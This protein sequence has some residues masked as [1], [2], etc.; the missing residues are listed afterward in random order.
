MQKVIFKDDSLSGN[1]KYIIPNYLPLTSENENDFDFFTFDLGT[2]A[3]ILKFENFLPFGLINQF[4][5]HFGRYED[6]K[7]FWRD[8]LLFTFQKKAKIL[9]HIDF[10]FLEI[11][12]YFGFK[13]V[14]STKDKDLLTKY[15]F[16]VTMCLY[17]DYSILDFEEYILFNNNAK[18][19][20]NF[21]IE[22]DLY[23]KFDLYERIYEKEECRPLDL[24][25]SIDDKHFINYNQLCISEN[26]SSIDSRIIDETRNLSSITKVLPIFPFQPFTNKQ[27]K[28]RKKAVIS[29]SK[30][31][32]EM[33]NTFRQY[34]VPLFE[35]NLIDPWYCTNLIAGEEWN[36]V[37][38]NKFEEADIIFFMV[39]EHFMSNKYVKEN[40]IKYII[41]KWDNGDKSIKI[42]PIILV[43]YPWQYGNGNYNLSRFTAL[44]YTAKAITDF[45]D[46]H[47]AWNIVSDAI[48]VMI[49]NDYN[50]G[51]QDDIFSK[52]IDRI[53]ERIING[54]MDA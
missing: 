43:S 45:Y 20:L 24:Y 18:E 11:K 13:R 30:M 15:L 37:I 6:K 29:Y 21:K 31:D 27:L 28:K 42:L 46:Q 19:T 51:N 49:E 9:I 4:I 17:W 41:D 7:K 48:R 14:T 39:S 23:T 33:V 38:K 52:Q 3:F 10:R 53:H 54:K 34:L 35:N 50:P 22:S 2:P 12:I 40:E 26:S 32:L 8:R 5:C 25:I 44:P 1:E 47:Q 16:Y 36:E